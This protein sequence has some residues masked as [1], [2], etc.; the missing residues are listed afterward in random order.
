MRTLNIKTIK[1]LQ[2]IWK[3]IGSLKKIR[4]LDLFL[5]CLFIFQSLAKEDDGKMTFKYSLFFLKAYSYNSRQ[6]SSDA[7]VIFILHLTPV[8]LLP[9]LPFFPLL[10]ILPLLSLDNLGL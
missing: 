4:I 3:N 5:V 8:P 9:L 2:K 6:K 10:P 7:L 1:E